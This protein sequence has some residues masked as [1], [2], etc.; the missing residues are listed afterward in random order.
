[1]RGRR[2]PQCKPSG[3]L[4]NPL[5]NCGH[6]WGISAIQSKFG[7]LSF[8]NP[9]KQ[10]A[11]VTRTLFI[12]DE[13]YPVGRGGIGRLMFNIVQQAKQ[14]TPA[15]DLHILLGR[16]KSADHKAVT[17]ALNGAA[18]VHYIESVADTSAWLGVKDI[19]KSIATNQS[20]NQ[21]FAGT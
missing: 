17:Q 11:P 20:L 9:N 16:P 12:L 10:V 19:T 15:L 5:L 18:Q 4:R 21:P 8:C 14:D 3:F 13:F 7:L 2:A 6:I 1:M